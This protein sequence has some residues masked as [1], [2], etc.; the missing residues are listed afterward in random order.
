MI[1]YL[2]SCEP[3]GIEELPFG[4]EAD[5]EKWIEAHTEHKRTSLWGTSAV[6]HDVQTW[7][8]ER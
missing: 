6:D 5:R 2:C 3:C 8:A 4:F 1:F 7:E